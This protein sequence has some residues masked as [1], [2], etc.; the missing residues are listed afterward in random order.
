MVSLALVNKSADL[1]TNFKNFFENTDK[2][3]IC[4]IRE[5]IL[6][7]LSKDKK[8]CDIAVYNRLGKNF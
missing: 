5:V 7:I 1:T 8:S 4:Q 6:F 3:Q 2:V